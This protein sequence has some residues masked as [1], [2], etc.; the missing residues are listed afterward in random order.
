MKLVWKNSN[1]KHNS[2]LAE[3]YRRIHLKSLAIYKKGDKFKTERGGI[4][5]TLKI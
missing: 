4:Y 1:E 2:E 5:G 3:V